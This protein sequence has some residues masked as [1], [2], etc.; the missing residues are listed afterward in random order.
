MIYWPASAASLL[1]DAH[2]EARNRSRLKTIK[3]LARLDGPLPLNPETAIRRATLTA[4]PVRQRPEDATQFRFFVV[5]KPI[6]TGLMR[7]H[8]G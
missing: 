4:P 2:S 3:E 1:A 5:D 7:P 8:W 6:R